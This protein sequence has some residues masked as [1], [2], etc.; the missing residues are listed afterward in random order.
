[1]GLEAGFDLSELFW[2]AQGEGPHVGRSTLFLRFG[3]CN[4]RCAWCDTPGTWRPSKECRFEIA[5]GSGLFEKAVNPVS[6]HRLLEAVQALAPPPGGFLSLTGG[7]PLLQPT[8]VAEAAEIG[9]NL[10][11]RVSLET[12][13][14]AVEALSQVIDRLDYVSMDWKLESDVMWANETP[15]AKSE[16]KGFSGLHTEFLSL[17]QRRKVDSCVKVVITSD[18]S[19]KELEEVCRVIASTAPDVPLILQPVTPYGR[20]QSQPS[21]EVLLGH[22][23]RCSESLADVRLIPQT[24]RVYGAR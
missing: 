4:L 8:A 19:D 18:S 13:G 7:E 12:H 24:H 5:P 15:Q 20:V 14:L 22:L 2:S 21:A 3:G 10:G 17:I 9:R 16:A 11:L 1:M 6:R 23:R